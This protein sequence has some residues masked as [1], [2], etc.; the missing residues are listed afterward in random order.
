MYDALAAFAIGL[1]LMLF[2]LALAWENKRL[3]LGE[4]LPLTEENRL[5][6]IAASWDGVTHVVDFRTV[7]FGPDSVIIAADIAFEPDLDTGEIDERISAI[8]DAIR[9]AHAGTEKVYIEPET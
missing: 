7:Y 3:L 8:E 6:D 9:E 5:R 2:A 4:S 1:M